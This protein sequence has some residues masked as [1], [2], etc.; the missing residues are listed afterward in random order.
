M[1]KKAHRYHLRLDQLST[2]TGAGEPASLE[3]DFSNHDDVLHIV[4]LMQAKP[5]FSDPDEA[6]Q[7][8]VGL[9]LFSEVMLRHRTDPLFTEVVQAFGPFM[10]KLKAS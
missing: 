4:R 3:F 7:F 9:K 8:A 6:A 1:E 10:K 5:L 2:K